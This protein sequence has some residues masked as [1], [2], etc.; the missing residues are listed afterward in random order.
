MPDRIRVPGCKVSTMALD[1]STLDDRGVLEIRYLPG[2]VT[3]ADLDEGRNAVAAA[4]S[5]SGIRKVFV[6]ASALSQ[7]PTLI[8][9]LRHN[10]AIA[11]DSILR[12]ARF[13]VVFRSLGRDERFLENTGVNRGVNLKC[14]TSKADALSWLDE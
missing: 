1:I 8:A 4:L 11:A 12:Q 5:E 13:A 3:G 10:A 2:H 14:F 6:D 9:M 7:M